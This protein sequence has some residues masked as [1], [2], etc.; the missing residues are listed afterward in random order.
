M[1][2]P[3]V[4]LL[5]SLAGI[6][7]ALVLP[8][9]SDWLLLAVPSTIASTILLL[10]AILG[11]QGPARPDLPALPAVIVDGSNVMHWRDGTPK[12]ETLREVI[13]ALERAGLAPGVVFDANAG[14]KLIGSYLHDDTLSAILGLPRNRVT[15]VNKGEPADPLILA[16]ARDQGARIVTNDRFRDWVDSFPFVGKPGTLIR[17]G[18]RGG[19]LWLDL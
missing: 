6:L 10:R 17:G 9:A 16:T 19:S 11:T 5:L 2:A 18:F 12:V 1:I 15:I 14:Y 3:V 4:L 13:V 7:C 8:D